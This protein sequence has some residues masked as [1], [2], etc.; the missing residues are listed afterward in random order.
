MR[1]STSEPMKTS[2]ACVIR[3]FAELTAFDMGISFPN[4]A[5]NKS[6]GLVP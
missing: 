5:A 3:I 2:A 6:C 4:T 1:A